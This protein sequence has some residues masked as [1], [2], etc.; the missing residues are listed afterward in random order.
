MQ[1]FGK[2]EKFRKNQKKVGKNS[3]PKISTKKFSAK[4]TRQN[5]ETFF[6]EFFGGK[7][8][9]VPILRHFEEEIPPNGPLRK[10]MYQKRTQ[11]C[12]TFQ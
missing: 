1:N 2:F 5:F 11:I 4:K 7:I 3:E 12:P 9:L 8:S 6:F 10:K